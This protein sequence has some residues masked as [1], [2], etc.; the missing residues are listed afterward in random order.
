MG[1][2]W[3][4]AW[5]NPAVWVNPTRWGEMYDVSGKTARVRARER[6]EQKNGS[7]K[8]TTG[9][10]SSQQSAIDAASS[11]KARQ[12]LISGNSQRLIASSGLTGNAS[13]GATARRRL[14]G[15]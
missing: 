14:I 9:D 1:G 11:E 2:D 8:T 15:I 10:L 6:D 7:T 4:K 5:I 12:L 3:L 13:S